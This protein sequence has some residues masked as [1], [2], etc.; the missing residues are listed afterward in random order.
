VV[1]NVYSATYHSKGQNECGKVDLKVEALA[2][3]VRRRE[4]AK[5]GRPTFFSAYSAIPPRGT[6]SRPHH[7]LP[8][9]TE[10]GRQRM[11]LSAVPGAGRSVACI[12]LRWILPFFRFG[13]AR[14]VESERCS[15]RKRR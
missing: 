1:S 10:R 12:F 14:M 3:Q 2:G 15:Q 4:L 9:G 7:L 8:C 13:R 6:S 5:G 11:R